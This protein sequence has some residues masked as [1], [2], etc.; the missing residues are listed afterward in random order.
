MATAVLFNPESTPVPNRVVRYL[1]SVQAGDYDGRPDAVVNTDPS[2]D[3]PQVAALDA[4]NVPMSQ[5]KVV[6]NNVVQLDQA[7][8]DAIAAAQAAAA[9]AAFAAF[10]EEVKARI[11]NQTDLRE[12][13][14]AILETVFELIVPQL[15]TLR[16]FHSLSAIDKDT[17]IATVKTTFK[18]NYDGKVDSWSA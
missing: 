11:I 4:A 16:A 15:N 2:G 8:L 18:D 14:A 12:L 7:D 17:V 10:K 13:T 6:G 3:N 9:A 1:R 5:W